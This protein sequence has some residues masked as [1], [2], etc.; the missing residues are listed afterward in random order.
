[1]PVNV[2]FKSQQQQ[3]QQKQQQPGTYCEMPEVVF[4]KNGNHISSSPPAIDYGPLPISAATKATLRAQTQVPQPQ[5]VEQRHHAQEYEEMPSPTDSPVLSQRIR[6][7]TQVRRTHAAH[8]AEY[9]GLPASAME[10]VKRAAMGDYGRIPYIPQTSSVGREDSTRT[11]VPT[12]TTQSPN[13]SCMKLTRSVS[14]QTPASHLG[15]LA[16]ISVEPITLSSSPSSSP[17]THKAST[18]TKLQKSFSDLSLGQ[19]FGKIFDSHNSNNNS[20]NSS[21]NA[22]SGFLRKKIS[23]PNT[24]LSRT[25]SFRE[26]VLCF[27]LLPLQQ[28]RNFCHLPLLFL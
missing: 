15:N 9:D 2:L 28:I 7:D 21:N 27:S 10:E 12:T 1:M 8:A 24:I 11:T 13:G 4:S 25:N 17:G 22:G 18:A 26:G 19:T 5:Q 23:P 20:S 6:T 3:Q 16:E 14:D